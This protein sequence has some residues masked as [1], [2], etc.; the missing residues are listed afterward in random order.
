MFII[1]FRNRNNDE[2]IELLYENIDEFFSDISNKKI[3]FEKTSIS[4]R[5][6]YIELE[7]QYIHDIKDLKDKE[8]FKQ[9]QFGL[10][11]SNILEKDF[12]SFIRNKKINDLLDD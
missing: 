8:N 4:D 6:Y 11:I 9:K 12:I 7:D 2:N 3:T 10:I 5:V 1:W